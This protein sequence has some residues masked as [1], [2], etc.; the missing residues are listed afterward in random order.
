MTASASGALRVTAVIPSHN[1]PR[2]LIKVLRELRNEPIDEVIIVDNGSA[3]DFGPLLAGMSVR[4]LKLRANE[5]V[6][7]R[8]RAADRAGGELLLMLDDDSYPQPGVVALMKD[9]FALFP[10]LG[11]VGGRVLEV[12]G[13][14]AHAGAGWCRGRLL[15]LVCS[16]QN[17]AAE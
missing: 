1:R 3:A 13:A 7:A 6:A 12:D 10:S 17:P 15:R 16:L 11:A 9:L 14:P 4:L 8:N 5:G 2:A